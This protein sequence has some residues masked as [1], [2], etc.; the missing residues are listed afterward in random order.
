ML[1]IPQR[2]RLPPGQFPAPIQRLRHARGARHE[3]GETLVDALFDVGHINL[4]RAVGHA[5]F[6]ADLAR[7]LN[8]FVDQRAGPT[9]LA[10]RDGEIALADQD[11]TRAWHGVEDGGQVVYSLDGF[12]LQNRQDLAVRIERPD[13]GAVEVFR[14]VEP[15][16]AQHVARSVSAASDRFLIGASAAWM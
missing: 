1:G 14:L 12:A 10:K 11:Q 15:P 9:L 4:R 6:L 16:V 7:A 13:V 8:R 3:E 2:A 5:A